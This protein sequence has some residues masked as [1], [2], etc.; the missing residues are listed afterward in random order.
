[1][2]DMKHFR[3]WQIEH[4]TARLKEETKTEAK[5]FLRRELHNL[6]KATIHVTQQHYQSE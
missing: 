2:I 3:A 5:A 1:M 4:Y 6:K